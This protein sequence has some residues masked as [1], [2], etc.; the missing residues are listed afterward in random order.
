MTIPNERM[1]TSA[2]EADV[3]A[4]TSSAT[5]PLIAAKLLNLE[6]QPGILSAGL[7]L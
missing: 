5:A 4:G 1:Q 2:T 7:S 6:E 3:A